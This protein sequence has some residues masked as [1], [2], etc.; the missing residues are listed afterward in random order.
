MQSNYDVL[1][2][3]FRFSSVRISLILEQRGEEVVM[4]LCEHSSALTRLYDRNNQR[5]GINGLVRQ[6]ELVQREPDQVKVSQFHESVVEVNKPVVSRAVE[7]LVV[8]NHHAQVVRWNVEV[9]VVQACKNSPLSTQMI[10]QSVDSLTSILKPAIELTVMQFRILI[11]DF[12]FISTKSGFRNINKTSNVFKFNL[13]K[14]SGKKH[15]QIDIKL[16]T[17]QNSVLLAGSVFD[18]VEHVVSLP[19]VSFVYSLYV[20]L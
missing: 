18:L 19:R 20:K 15:F 1:W 6:Y 4:R 5:N 2:F 9:D 16:Q 14:I 7:S 8:V 12:C 13:R 10:R 11:W 17:P 3:R